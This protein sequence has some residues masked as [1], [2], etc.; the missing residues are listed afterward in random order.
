MPKIDESD[1]ALKCSLL[2][3]GKEQRVSNTDYACLCMKNSADRCR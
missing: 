2:G 1:D 3:F